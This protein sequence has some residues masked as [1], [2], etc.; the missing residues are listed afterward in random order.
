MKFE[1]WCMSK[2][3]GLVGNFA[4]IKL[5]LNAQRG[6]ATLGLLEAL[7][8]HWTYPEKILL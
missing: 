5:I 8:H 3:H 4:S 2:A 7:F 1:R 6:I